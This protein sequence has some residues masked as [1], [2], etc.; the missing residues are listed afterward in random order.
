[1]KRIFPP[2][3]LLFLLAL[4]LL[5]ACEQAAPATMPPDLIGK[6]NPIAAGDDT[7]IA[8]G[9]K[10]F[11]DICSNCHGES[12]RGDGPSAASLVPPP[13][14]LVDLSKIQSDDYLFWRIS[15]G[16]EGTVMVAWKDNLS[17][18]EIWQ[19]ISYIKTLQ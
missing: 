3:L 2:I 8:A 6:T 10:N 14:N 4:I 11:N 12:G 16:K 9:K 1:M 7:A 19:V 18:Q 5:S 15:Y 13:A 17:E